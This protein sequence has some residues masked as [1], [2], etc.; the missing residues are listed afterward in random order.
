[1]CVCTL[2]IDP[3]GLYTLSKHSTLNSTPDIYS[4]IAKEIAMSFGQAIYNI[5]KKMKLV[6]INRHL[7]T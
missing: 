6:D 3:K 1:M 4:I 5:E 7:H 2:G